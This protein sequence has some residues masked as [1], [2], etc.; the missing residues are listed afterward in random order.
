MMNHNDFIEKDS[1]AH[2][3]RSLKYFNE[4]LLQAKY[5]IVR[6]LIGQMRGNVISIDITLDN[7]SKK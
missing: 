6:A 4:L 2:A 3:K 5:W 7:V 1:F